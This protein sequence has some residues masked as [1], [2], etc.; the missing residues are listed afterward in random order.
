MGNPNNKIV[1]LRGEQGGLYVNDTSAHTGNF[2]ALKAA[3]G[4][5][6]VFSAITSNITSLPSNYTI[7]EN[8]WL[9]ARVTGFTLASGAVIAY[10]FDGLTDPS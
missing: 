7:A 8:D 6:A 5:D 10:N 1:N 9:L 2:V 3:P 4:A